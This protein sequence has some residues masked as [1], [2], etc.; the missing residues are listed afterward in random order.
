[1]K[2]N[3]NDYT[4]NPWTLIDL[5]PSADSPEIEAA[6]S[7]I[8]TGIKEFEMNRSRLTNDISVADFLEI[9]QQLEGLYRVSSSLNG[10]AGLWFSEN[11][12][13][14]LAQTLSARVD[15]IN[16]VASNQILF[17]SLWWK[18]LENSQAERLLLA[19]GDFRYWLEEIRHFKPF[20]LT[21]AE[22]KIINLKDVTG[23]NALNMLYDSITN[24][25]TFKLEVEG[26][27]LDLT[28]G[29]LMVY[30]R[31]SDPDLRA[32]AYQSL[33]Q[34]YSH[35]API[36]GQ[37]YQTI[38]RDWRN[39]N[40]GLRK[41]A[42]PISTR[43][44]VND[45]P[46]EVVDTLLEVSAKNATIFQRFFRLKARVIGVERLRRYDV[47]APVG[48]SNKK[49]E[50]NAAAE[51]VLDAFQDFDPE[52]AT[53]AERVFNENHL[54]SEIR[55]GKTGGA[56]CY[57]VRPDLTPWVMLNYQGRTDDVSTMAHELGHAI[58]GMLASGHSIFTHH[59]CLPLAETA[60]TFGEM[61]LVD[62]LLKDEPDKE[63]RR[64][65]LFRQIDDSYATITR[66]AFFAMFERQAHDMIYHGASI[67]DL[68]QAYFEN[69]QQQ[70]GDSV[71]ISD[72]FRWEW[73]SVPH[74]FNVPFYVY[75][76]SFGQL[77]VLSLYQQYKAEGDSF[78]PRYMEILRAGGSIA[79]VKLLGQAGIE[80]HKPEFWQGGYDILGGLV[81][82][83]EKM[84]NPCF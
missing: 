46:D 43:N 33:Y 26:K 32:R 75:A 30:V 14:Q 69:L 48:E 56:F 80:I 39:E 40:I 20:T 36:L 31:Q 82:Q 52:M 74:I 7:K 50:F 63:V 28:R 19:S 67:D 24:R 81:D 16:A 11:T 59:P 41:Y 70:F 64:D 6:F 61:I 71:E 60:S 77:L 54:D 37:I 3:Q 34:V 17:F 79:P 10:Y 55:K 4:Q 1:M 68:A 27:E 18:D 25:F 8:Q 21:E 53:L 83:L 42:N 35:E 9:V 45:I 51:M 65:L 73:V 78:K 57:T 29:E 72:E 15:Q 66:Q 58:H 22:E 44:L 49:F 5:F 2:T 84:E 12:Q 76:Y 47:Y 62:R 23:V 13:N 38:A